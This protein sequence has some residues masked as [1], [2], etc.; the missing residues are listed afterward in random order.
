MLPETRFHSTSIMSSLDESQAYPVESLLSA[1][2]A[3]SD[4][5][6]VS[7]D[8]NGFVTSWNDGA[9]RLFGYSREEMIGRPISVLIP[10][11]LLSEEDEILRKIRSGQRVDHFETVRIRKDGRKVDVS[12]TIS[13]I[14]DSTGRVMGASKIARDITER[15]A[16]VAALDRQ[17]KKLAILNRVSLAFSGELDLQRLVQAVTDAGRELSGAAFGAF[18]YNVTSETG[19]S[20]RLFTLS[21]APREAFEKFGM[22]RNTP[23][24]AP[25]FAGEGVVRIADV[26]RDPRYGTMS[27]HHGMPEGHLPVR[28]HLAVPVVSR[29]G[30]VLGGLFFGHPDPDVFQQESEELI[31]ALAANASVAIDNAQ[32]YSDLENELEH[33]RT[34]E[35]ALKE[36]ETLSTSIFDSTPDCI[37]V[38][39]PDGSIQRMNNPGLKLFGLAET[40]GR[41]WQDIWPRYLR[42]VIERSI[43]LALRGSVERFQSQFEVHGELKWWDVIISPLRDDSDSITRLIAT[44]RDITA[45]KIAESEAQSA[46]EEAIRQ[47]RMKDEFLATL[48]HEL[49]TPLQAILGWTHLL[50]S[51]RMS[52]AQHQEGLEVIVRN[53]QGQTRIIED[54]L[55]MN[56]IVSGKVRLDI[57]PVCL[58]GILQEAV[59]TVRP[60]A[61]AKQIELI[62][63][64]DTPSETVGGDPDRLQQVFWNLLSNAIKFTPA[65]G[66]V[67]IRLE[68]TGHHLQVS[69][70]D[71]GAGID[72]AFLPFVFERFRQADPTITRK[73]GGLGLGLSIVKNLT[74]LH[75]GAVRATSPGSG[76]GATFEVTF[77]IQDSPEQQ[78]ATPPRPFRA[79]ALQPPGQLQDIKV[80]VV[81]D[82]QDG[83]QLV[84]HLLTNAG[85][86][87]SLA[88]SSDEA[89]ESITHDCPDLLISDIG[90][91]GRDGYSL[92]RQVRGTPGEPGRIPAL[93]LTAYT[94]TEDRQRAISEGFH[95]H[96]AKPADPHELLE[97]VARLVHARTG[98]A[99]D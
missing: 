88:R 50:K 7:K 92:I 86:K 93:A 63:T 26:T 22:P 69:V 25:T 6:I 71:N 40:G 87:V 18:F 68:K 21:G 81:D 77:P 84:A 55:D 70:T 89:F 65:G 73:H 96:L 29:R 35:R 11:E 13:P 8:L 51:G 41:Y 47:S 23:I 82:E 38:M 58:A 19:E 39:D 34:L 12:L 1:I 3:S 52:Q 31:T 72:P 98:P 75:G 30:H 91:P 95:M 36:S 20:Y 66:R 85:A 56:R 43:E 53:T 15:K 2:I 44:S 97:I 14:R 57:Q 79:E 48:S 67:T 61:Q 42:P 4:D 64:I 59:E 10:T 99:S 45:L 54:L 83:R 76:K 27:P 33:H 90:M 94:R 17:S 60:S 46:K 78:E 32:L 28:S 49:R 9:A 80:L 74:E 16:A 5:C 24:F 37:M 62:L